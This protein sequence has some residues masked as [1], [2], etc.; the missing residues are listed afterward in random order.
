MYSF[1]KTSRLCSKKLIEDL[2]AGGA[3]SFSAF[4][5]RVVAKEMGE[6]MVHTNNTQVLMSVS[7]HRLHH[8]VDRNRAKRQMREA[9]RLNQNIIREKPPMAIAFVW[10]SNEPVSSRKVHASM[11]K[12][13]SKLSD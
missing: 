1:P 9:Y 11:I 10:L 6:G 7:K 4:P 8:A 2:F 3:Q 13:L 12:L 5:L